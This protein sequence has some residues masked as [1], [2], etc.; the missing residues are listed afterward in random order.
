V[1][2]EDREFTDPAVLTAGVSEGWAEPV[3]DPTL[4]DWPAR[5]A[6]ALIPFDVVDG[7]PVSPGPASRVRRGRN[8]LGLWGENAMA[9]ALVTACTA[10]G[11]RWLLLVERA[12]GRGWAVPGGA[13][14]PGESPMAA[15]RR[16][17]A[18]ET[19]LA[20]PAELWRAG[21]PRY[22][23]DPRGSD[24]AWA[25]TVAARADLGA[26]TELPSVQGADDASRAAWVRADSLTG[27]EQ[28][29][30]DIYDGGVFPAHV[31]LLRDA[32]AT[33][34]DCEARPDAGPRLA[35]QQVH[36]DA[37]RRAGEEALAR[38]P[39]DQPVV[40][41]IDEVR[42]DPPVHEMWHDLSTG[43][44]DALAAALVSLR[45]AYDVMDSR[46]QVLRRQGES[47]RIPPR[48]LSVT[49][50]SPGPLLESAEHGDEAR[51]LMRAIAMR[52]RAVEVRLAL[53]GVVPRGDL[54]VV[55]AVDEVQEL[56]GMPRTGRTGKVDVSRLLDAAPPGLVIG[57]GPRRPGRLERRALLLVGAAQDLSMG[58]FG[59]VPVRYEWQRWAISRG[60]G[61]AW[62]LLRR[63]RE[64][65]ESR[66]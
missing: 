49:L 63:V 54:A 36:L 8:G 39:Q 11:A 52:G 10:D 44:P 60:V 65:Q 66:R 9:D 62:P 30:C 41:A 32:L 46:L 21:E 35:A 33:A 2:A 22:V 57:P 6:A 19:G 56:V 31:D 12:D 45:E 1:R 18:E 3:T 50:S 16:E 28:A 59:R 25:V 23:P 4:I 17:L 29:L 5:Q 55:P 61:L 51:T 37:L 14:D 58:I 20:V 15:A 38:A 34:G 64:V 53:T 42:D 13:I 43:H 48:R 47:Q 27:L 24:E 7:R 26:V 40:L